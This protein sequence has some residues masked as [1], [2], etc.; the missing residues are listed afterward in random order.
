MSKNDI[1]DICS[2][3]RGYYKIMSVNFNI[4]TVLFF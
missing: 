4:L 1:A 2:N 3:F